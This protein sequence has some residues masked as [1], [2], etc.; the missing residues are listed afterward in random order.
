M[1]KEWEP[2]HGKLSAEATKKLTE[3]EAEH[4]FSSDMN[5]VNLYTLESTY[6][7]ATPLYVLLKE[8]LYLYF[9]HTY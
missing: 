3:F 1:S 6:K 7:V 5:L 2:K 4:P 9:K 8:E